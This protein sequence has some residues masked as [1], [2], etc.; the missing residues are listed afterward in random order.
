MADELLPEE[1]RLAALRKLI[2]AQAASSK[3]N[4]KLLGQVREQIEVEKQLE[5]LKK[6]I[7]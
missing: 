6:F 1:R 3:E 5:Q 4:A 7:I 2:Q